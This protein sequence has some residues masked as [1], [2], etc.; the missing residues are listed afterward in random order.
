[1]RDRVWV[2]AYSTAGT[3]SGLW[4]CADPRAT[5]PTF[6]QKATRHFARGFALDPRDPGRAYLT[7]SP[8]ANSGKAGADTT[9]TFGLETT[10]AIDAAQPAWTSLNRGKQWR[11]A[12]PVV[13][14]PFDSTV[15]Y[16]GEPGNGALRLT[17]R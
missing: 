16:V 9:L 3:R 11:F 17:R 14:D 5:K 1:V 12:W 4:M 7:T 13:V 10:E 15:V 8:A 2:V 6:A